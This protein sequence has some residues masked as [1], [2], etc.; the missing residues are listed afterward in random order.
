MSVTVL[1]DYW[2]HLAT[3]A[4]VYS[5]IFLSITVI[6][7]IGGQVS[8]CQASFAGIGAFTAGQLATSHGVSILVGIL[9][10]AA[11]AAAVGALLAI[12]A[13][14]LGGITF[15]LATLAF[16]L[17]ADNVLFPL[18]WFGG[19]TTG[20]NVPRPIVGPV[21]F[22]NTRAFFLLC[23]GVLV[24]VAA[25]VIRVREGTTG[26][27]LDALRGSDLAA[28]TIGIAPAR[29]RVVALA[30]SAG[31][32]GLGGGLYASLE[33]PIGP[34][35]FN[36]F[37]SLVF[38]V[39]VLT[40]GM[41]TVEGAINAAAALVLL[42]QLLDLLPARYGVLEFALFGYG[43]VTFVKHPEGIVE[44]QKRLSMQRLARFAERW[45]ARSS[46]GDDDGH[47]GGGDVPRPRG[48]RHE[49]RQ[50]VEERR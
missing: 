15:A 12:P 6:T 42:P 24:I 9:I 17:M 7:G 41:R 26:R 4:V 33:G 50:P 39:L 32:A 35:N 48:D 19:G 11:V 5:V 3:T 14:R 31:I 36:Y 34:D 2:L 47:N 29:T 10:G 23:V 18:S 25:V 40:T 49:V 16:A 13:L 38:I 1:S 30:L 43:A 45:S 46:S 27:F 21:N 44:F 8:L 22:T 37:L 28:R 20:I